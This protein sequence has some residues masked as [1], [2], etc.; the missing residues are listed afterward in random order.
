MPR[1][2]AIIHTVGELVPVYKEMCGSLLPTVTCFHVCDEGILRTL[3]EHKE[4]TSRTVLRLAELASRA[5]QDGADLIL[6]TCSSVSPAV[7]LVQPLVDVPIMKID[8]PMSD[9]AVEMGQRIG[10]LATARSA[11]GPVTSLV[12]ERADQ[13]G[14]NVEVRSLLL[15]G[16]LEKLQAG[17]PLAHD[18]A[19]VAGILQ[20]SADCDVVVLAQ[21]SMARALESL[22]E[23][24]R[25]CPVLTNA[26][27][28]LLRVAQRLEGCV[29]DRAA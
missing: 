20:L 18:A 7:D 8:E 3:S 17:D 11:V 5:Q 19:V 29:A 28:G 14:R 6:V 4:L 1:V 25:P 12:R 21:G 15:E 13:F 22:P 26:R 16:A 23:S 2:L 27:L 10:V 9:A 24:E